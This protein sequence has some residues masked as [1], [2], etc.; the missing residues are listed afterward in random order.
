MK[1]L[2]M[3]LFIICIGCG[4]APSTPQWYDEVESP[5]VNLSPYQDIDNKSQPTLKCV[6]ERNYETLDQ[7]EWN[8]P[9]KP[10][11]IKI[12]KYRIKNTEQTFTFKIREYYANEGLVEI[13]FRKTKRK[14]F[15]NNTLAQ[16]KNFKR[17]VLHEG[18]PTDVYS[19]DELVHCLFNNP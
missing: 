1:K 10:E 2:N 19:S 13:L 12:L 8:I 16:P 18:V 14:D 9:A 3:M 17:A 15:Q 6:V 5:S 11:I 7:F 4:K